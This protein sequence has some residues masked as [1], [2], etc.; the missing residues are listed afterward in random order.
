MKVWSGVKSILERTPFR[1]KF[2]IGFI[3]VAF[4]IMGLVT[5]HAYTK[6]RSKYKTTSI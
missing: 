1:V 6:G 5:L 4:F 2:Y 3:L